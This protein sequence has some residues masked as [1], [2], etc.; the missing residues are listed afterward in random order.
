MQI[1]TTISL[2]PDDVKKILADY[3]KQKG[4]EVDEK[5]VRFKV[6]EVGYYGGSYDLISAECDVKQEI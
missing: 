2:K 6:G 5:N 3:L 4:Y 1:N